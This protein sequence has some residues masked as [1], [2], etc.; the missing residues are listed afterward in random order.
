M[1]Q[2][3]VAKRRVEQVEKIEQRRVARRDVDRD[4]RKVESSC[5]HRRRGHPGAFMK[6]EAASLGQSAGREDD[7]DTFC[8]YCLPD[9]FHDLAHAL[10]RPFFGAP[11]NRG[12][13][14]IKLRKDPQNIPVGKKIHIRA[15]LREGLVKD[16]SVS[17]TG[18]V[19]AHDEARPAGGKFAQI[20]CMDM[21][22][23]LPAHDRE[24][25]L[26]IKRSQPFECGQR[27]V[28]TEQRTQDRPRHCQAG[29]AAE[30]PG[31]TFLDQAA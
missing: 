8:R 27:L 19:V 13:L 18:G 3:D 25:L 21:L 15:H 5:K 7:P 4:N 24:N 28:I 11:F 17:D 23:K 6:L 22:C 9:E 12:D 29:A 31:R 20:M 16:D 30:E 10:M 2:G 26:A 14:A 1:K